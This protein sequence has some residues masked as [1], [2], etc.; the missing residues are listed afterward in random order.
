MERLTKTQRQR[1]IVDMSALSLLNS[2]IQSFQG[3][4]LYPLFD[5][6]F[7]RAFRACGLEKLY[8]RTIGPES[9]DPEDLISDSISHERYATPH[10]RWHHSKNCYELF[11]VSKDDQHRM[12]QGTDPA[13]IVED[14][15]CWEGGVTKAEL[16]EYWPWRGF[17]RLFI[18]ELLSADIDVQYAK[19]VKETKHTIQNWWNCLTDKQRTDIVNAKNTI[20]QNTA[21]TICANG[22]YV[23]CTDDIP[24]DWSRPYS[25]LPEDAEWLDS[26][27]NNEHIQ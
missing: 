1:E 2:G 21:A 24:S 10:A 13:V 25:L 9:K 11:F 3:S 6:A 27:P 15:I 16:Y 8:P 23:L 22:G 14:I 20:S 26:L 4:M 7:E 5:Y 17:G 18:S 12:E 19:G